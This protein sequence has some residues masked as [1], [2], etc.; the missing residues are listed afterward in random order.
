D[1]Y[2]AEGQLGRGGWTWYTGSASWMY[3]VG[4]E[5]ILGL[6]RKGDALVVQPRAPLAWAEYRIDYRFGE[7]S[8]AIRVVRDETVTAVET[9][10]DGTALRDGRIP[11][12]DDGRRHDVIVKR[13]PR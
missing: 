10:V 13:P 3:R 11:L 6:E 8:Y 9:T 1:V 12:V 5:G 7:S 4:V 2:T